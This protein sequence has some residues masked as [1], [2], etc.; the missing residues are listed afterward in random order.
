MNEFFVAG[1]QGRTQGQASNGAEMEQSWRVRDAQRATLAEGLLRLNQEGSQKDATLP[2]PSRPFSLDTL[3]PGQALTRLIQTYSSQKAPW[4]RNQLVSASQ[5]WRDQGVHPTEDAFFYTDLRAM[6]II[7]HAI[8]E[9][10]I[11]KRLGGEV[12]AGFQRLSLLHPQAS[13][14]RALLD[15]A[16]YIYAYGLDDTTDQAP[17]PHLDTLQPP[18]FLRFTIRPELQTGLEWFW[19]VVIDEPRLRT[20]LLAQHTEGDLWSHQQNARRYMG[21]W[22]FDPPTVADI[23]T[24]LRR[25][26]RTLFY[27]AP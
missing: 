10:I 7:S 8:E 15:S 26:G 5:Q 3:P 20:A 25:A 27:G 19:F 17:N 9:H 18:R 6:N 16:H 22:T 4:L 13:R 14:Y 21:L 12:Y 11:A 1:G 2:P 23:V 24:I